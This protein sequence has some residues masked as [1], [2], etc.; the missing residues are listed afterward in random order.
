MGGFVYGLLT[1]RLPAL[2]TSGVLDGLPG[3][4]ED[5]VAEPLFVLGV[6]FVLLVLFAPQ[7]IA[8]TVDG[9]RA[10]LSRRVTS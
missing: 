5:V 1:L 4:V 8:G 2:S 7:G 3:P 6:L 10:R 9:L